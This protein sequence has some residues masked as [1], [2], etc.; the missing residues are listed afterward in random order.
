[1]QMERCPHEMLWAGMCQA[2]GKSKDEMAAERETQVRASDSVLQNA[3][4]APARCSCPC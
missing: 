4:R 1:M 2:C 3:E